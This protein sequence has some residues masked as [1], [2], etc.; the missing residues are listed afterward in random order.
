M[1][2]NLIKSESFAVVTHEELETLINSISPEFVKIGMWKKSGHPDKYQKYVFNFKPG[3]FTK[4]PKSISD[5]FPSDWANPILWTS[6]S[7]REL[8][9]DYTKI[10]KMLSLNANTYHICA[11]DSASLFKLSEMHQHGEEYQ[12]ESHVLNF[13]HEVDR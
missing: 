8:L 6:M 10:K 9:D 5:Y 4:T 11:S 7:I 1:F 3:I 12:N 13:I 2:N